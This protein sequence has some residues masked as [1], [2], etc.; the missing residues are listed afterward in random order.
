MIFEKKHGGWKFLLTNHL[1]SSW[2][3]GEY[4]SIESYRKIFRC[5]DMP[6]LDYLGTAVGR[7]L[8]VVTVVFASTFHP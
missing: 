1:I 6:I 5:Q 7:L 8:V 4:L 3:R 2:F